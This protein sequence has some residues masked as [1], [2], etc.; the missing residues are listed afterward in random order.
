MASV[1]ASCNE[2]IGEAAGQVWHC[3][4]EN[5][6]LSLTKLTKDVELPRD[7]VMQAI[8]WLAREDKIELVESNRR[9]FVSLR[10]VA[11]GD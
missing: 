1:I 5:G 2:Q 6:R 3:L 4:Q 9:R 8:G 10:E 11:I 7:V